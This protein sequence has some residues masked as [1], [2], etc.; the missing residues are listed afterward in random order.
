MIRLNPPIYWTTSGVYKKKSWTRSIIDTVSVLYLF[1]FTLLA[2]CVSNMCTSRKYIENL[3]KINHWFYRVSYYNF[4]NHINT[5]WDDKLIIFRTSCFYIMKNTCLSCS[6]YTCKNKMYVFCVH[7]MKWNRE[8]YTG[9]IATYV[10]HIFNIRWT[11]MYV[12]KH[13]FAIKKPDHHMFTIYLTYVKQI[14]S[15][16]IW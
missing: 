8:Y 7:F 14:F 5:A 11:Y 16:N 3:S 9:K 12:I 1:C 6:L 15:I 4:D 13:M 10:Q 2:N